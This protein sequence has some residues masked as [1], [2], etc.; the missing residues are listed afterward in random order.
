MGRVLQKEQL[1][2]DQRGIMRVSHIYN[3]LA[4]T[5]HLHATHVN[6]VIGVDNFNI[7][8]DLPNQTR[9]VSPSPYYVA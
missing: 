7:P 1:L 5:V 2:L 3:K 8:I 9:I 4:I 6:R